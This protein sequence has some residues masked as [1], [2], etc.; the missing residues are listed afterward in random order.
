MSRRAL[1]AAVLAALL[2]A[3]AAAGA[4][5]KPRP[6]AR[7]RA[8]ARS[9]ARAAETFLSGID[10][11]ETDTLAS[12]KSDFDSCSATYANKVDDTR[13]TGLEAFLSQADAMARIPGLWRS[14]L[15]HWDAL[16][17]RDQTLKLVVAV[18]HS[19][20]PEVRKLGAAPRQ[21][22]ICEVLAAWEASGWSS[23]YIT[24][25]ESAW[26]SAIPV[27]G[28]AIDAARGRV[29]KVVPQLRALGLGD[30]EI[31]NVLIA[32]L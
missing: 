25:M 14:M 29:Q 13:L 19:Q 6:T 32:V 23:T 15:A 1:V 20:A 2:L 22:S 31:A 28:A 9:L 26:S 17:V 10:A 18:A 3:G 12:V 27:D 30:A 7:D 24:D 16:H 8:A 4:K 21:G 5:P 11:A